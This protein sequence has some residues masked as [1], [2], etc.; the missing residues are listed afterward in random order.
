MTRS[1]PGGRTGATVGGFVAKGRRGERL[2]VVTAY[3]ALFA[4]LVEEAHVDAILVGDSVGNVLAGYE[5]T[6]PVTLGQMIYHAAAVRR[7][8]PSSLV[9]VDMPFL[10]Y[11][12]SIPTALRNCGRVVQ[13]TGAQAVKLEGGHATAARTV[14]AVVELGVPVMGHLGHTPQARLVQGWGRVQG[15]EPEAAARMVDEARRLEDAGAFSIVLEL[16]PADVAARVTEAVTI[17]TIG[18]GAG[19]RCTGQVLV[20]P[21]LLG[22]TDTFAPKFLKRYANLA[23]AVRTA[24]RAYAD[25]VRTGTYPDAAHSF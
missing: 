4:R 17:P 20:L 14:A 15:R 2:A 22:L 5:T 1:G 18:I 8:A 23:D 24:V 9:I 13:R 25:D 19:P 11:Q 3:D 6:L 7:G 16:V 12:V 21:D 10:T